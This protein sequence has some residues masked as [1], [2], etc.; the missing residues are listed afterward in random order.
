MAVSTR[1]RAVSPLTA[2]LGGLVLFPGS[3]AAQGGPTCAPG[4]THVATFTVYEDGDRAPLVATHDVSVLAEWSGDVERPQLSAP[5]GVRVVSTR[6]REIRV[7]APVAASLAITATWEQEADPGNPDSTARCVATQTTALPV[8]ATERGRAVYG[9]HRGG[10]DA[11]A[12]FA[13][14][15][16]RDRADFSPLTI[17]ARVARAA[18]FPARSTRARTLTVPMRR[19]DEVR[20]RKRLPSA[21]YITTPIKCRLFSLTCGRLTT[22]VYALG[23]TRRGSRRELRRQ[24]GE[25]L[26][27]T[28][29]KRRA[30][31]NG[32]RIHAHVFSVGFRGP[33]TLGYDIQVRQSGE[34]LA[35]VRRAARCR[36]EVRFGFKRL[37]CRVLRSRD[38]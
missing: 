35:R 36:P 3:A 21:A 33:R 15:P 37:T 17:S 2:A 31:P 6:P 10:F 18:R 30:A 19:V 8:L 28:Q 5:A 20:Y 9:I 29:P 22:D 38:G 32:V 4:N 26:A 27:R 24:F 12:S 23:P 11:M 14:L 1:L 13:V 16:D 34:L 7:I 25:L